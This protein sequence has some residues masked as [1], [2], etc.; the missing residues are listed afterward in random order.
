LNLPRDAALLDEAD[1]LP[2]AAA[3]SLRRRPL[4]CIAPSAAVTDWTERGAA[5]LAELNRE[6]PS[7]PSPAAPRVADLDHAFS[8][9]RGCAKRKADSASL[10]F[11]RPITW[12]PGNNPYATPDRPATPRGPFCLDRDP[13]AA[14]AHRFRSITLL[15]GLLEGPGDPLWRQCVPISPNWKQV[16]TPE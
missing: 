1:S 3:T 6:R 13:L 2:S 14:V 7:A 16:P 9:R 8:R 5:L 11:R 12:N 15:S 4:A 10:I